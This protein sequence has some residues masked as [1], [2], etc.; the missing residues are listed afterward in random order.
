MTDGTHLTT[1]GPGAPPASPVETLPANLVLA[2]RTR[3]MANVLLDCVGLI[4]CAA[5]VKSV[6]H[7]SDPDDDSI[8]LFATMF[9]YYLGFEAALGETPGKLLTG[10]RVV[11]DSG[12][13]PS[14]MQILSRTC[15]RFIPFEP[16]SFFGPEVYGWHD[17]LSRTRVVRR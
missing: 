4:T 16:L 14:F 3:R 1:D 5:I 8:V 2:T 13:K 17:R 11:T 6:L 9:V 15:T 12:G 10:T 7:L